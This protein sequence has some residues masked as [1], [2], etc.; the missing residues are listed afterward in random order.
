MSLLK[1]RCHA[2]FMGHIHKRII[3]EYG[4]T[5]YITLENYGAAD[6]TGVFCRVSVSESGVSYQ[7]ER[8]F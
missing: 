2:L 1:N 8:V 6:A 4:G 3:Q 5:M 7:F